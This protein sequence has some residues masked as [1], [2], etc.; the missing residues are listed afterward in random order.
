MEDEKLIAGREDILPS[1]QG[2]SRLKMLMEGN[3]EEYQRKERNNMII[4]FAL[5]L[6][7]FFAIVHDKND[8]DNLKAEKAA[9]IDRYVRQTYG[10][11][12]D[13]FEVSEHIGEH[14]DYTTA[15]R[16]GNYRLAY[17]S[18]S[19]KDPEW[20]RGFT[21]VADMDGNIVFNG[22]QTNYLK[23]SAV[24][25]ARD[26]DYYRAVNKVES[27]L[28][29]RA[30][31]KEY[32]TMLDNIYLFGDFDA[33]GNVYSEH[34]SYAYSVYTGPVLDTDSPPSVNELAT[35]YGKLELE[36]NLA[37]PTLQKYR[38]IIILCRS[39]MAD[40]DVAYACADII[41]NSKAEIGRGD[42]I[43]FTYAEMH[44]PDFEQTL[45][46]TLSEYIAE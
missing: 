19:Y 39:C 31:E 42:K 14:Y 36:I 25:S 38:D 22:Y 33:K 46:D 7:V 17:V 1:D 41:I 11:Q 6:M 26:Y 9:Y 8:A 35:E 28:C 15:D 45:T 10:T 13:K 37:K 2:Y 43:S 29:I 32:I 44:S 12:F 21:I 30:G 5:A 34:D 4:F 23:G 27:A 20:N 18:R 40:R 24:F 3:E 16:Y